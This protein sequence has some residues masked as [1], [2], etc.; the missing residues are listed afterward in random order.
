M[1]ELE[2]TK[3]ISISAVLFL[4]V[5]LIGFL[6][7][8]KPEHIFQ[9]NAKQTLAELNKKEYILTQ[10][11]LN[12]LDPSK[13][14]LIDIRNSYEYAKGH[15]KGAINISAHQV[16]NKET[17]NLFQKTINEGKTIVVYGEDPD[18][19]SGAW[20]L[21]YQLGYENAKILCVTTSYVNNKFEISNY[22]LEKPAVNFA[23]V[24][25]ASSD[26]SATEVKKPVKKVITVKKKKKRVAEGGC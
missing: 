23:E 10:D 15:I 18:M 12:S 1:K 22:N 6:T 21:L 17:K 2:K 13:Y 8:K 20:M 24:I 25:K 3:R 4:L 26:V 5:I 19:A 9:K 14:A 16:F 7:F 11:Q